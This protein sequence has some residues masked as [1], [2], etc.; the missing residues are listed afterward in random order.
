METTEYIELISQLIT[1]NPLFVFIAVIFVGKLMLDNQEKKYQ[2][3]HRIEKEYLHRTLTN[4][5]D[6][7][8]TIT[9]TVYNRIHSLAVKVEKSCDFNKECGYPIND[10]YQQMMIYRMTMLHIFRGKIFNYIKSSILKNGYHEFTKDQLEKYY[11]LKGEKIYRDVVDELKISLEKAAPDIYKLIG[12]G[13]SVE[14]SIE[15]FKKVIEFSLEN[16]KL[17]EEK[18]KEVTKKY[19][20]RNLLKN[21]KGK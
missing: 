2:A 13:Y 11:K 18:I 10:I 5:E 12:N 7:L 20:L 4:V 9:S 17:M 6:V 8:D 21:L 19:S 15:S 16:D 1:T 3:V 14:E